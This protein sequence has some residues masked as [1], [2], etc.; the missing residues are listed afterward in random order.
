MSSHYHVL[1]VVVYGKVGQVR[2]CALGIVLKNCVVSVKNLVFVTR[3]VLHYNKLQYNKQ[4]TNSQ[5]PQ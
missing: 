4:C 3:G 2:C 5:S 1:T